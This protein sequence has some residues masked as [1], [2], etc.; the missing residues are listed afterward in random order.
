MLH[1][2]NKEGFIVK[3]PEERRQVI[4]DS[5]KEAMRE[6]IA[7]HPHAV[8]IP[9]KGTGPDTTTVVMRDLNSKYLVWR[10]FLFFELK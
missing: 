9:K 10:T 7:G 8:Y 1:D 2:G 3:E 5:L 4:P 6:W